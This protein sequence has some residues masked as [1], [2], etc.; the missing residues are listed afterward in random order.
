[1]AIASWFWS[2][3]AAMKA[4]R[5]LLEYRVMEFERYG[6]R[7]ETREGRGIEQTQKNLPVWELIDQPT[8]ANLG[9]LALARRYSLCRRS[10]WRCWRFPC[11]SSI[12]GRGVPTT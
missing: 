6:V 2:V 5:V 10:I 11:P 4:R 3:G 7:I 8:P 12:R 9:E 1:M